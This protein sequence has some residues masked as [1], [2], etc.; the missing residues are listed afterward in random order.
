V[1]PARASYR[2]AE[3]IHRKMIQP[4]DDAASLDASMAHLDDPHVDALLAIRGGEAVA[5][6][7]VLSMGEVG[8]VDQLYVVDGARRQGVGTTMLAH[9]LE[10][11]ARSVFKHVMAGVGASDTSSARCFDAFG[12]RK[13]GEMAVWDTPDSAG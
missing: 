4:L 3:A 12:F 5:H 7:A 9:A 1:I 11:C 13:V 8:L 10:V 2:H 6:V